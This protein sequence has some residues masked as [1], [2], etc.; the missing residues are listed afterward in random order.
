MYPFDR[1]VGFQI[2]D[3]LSMETVRDTGQNVY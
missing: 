1:L 3:C 2:V